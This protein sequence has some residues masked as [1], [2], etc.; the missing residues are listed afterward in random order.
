MGTHDDYDGF[1]EYATDDYDPGRYC[2]LE[3]EWDAMMDY[4]EDVSRG[5]TEGWFYPD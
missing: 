4:A 1:E 5:H 2:E 3:D